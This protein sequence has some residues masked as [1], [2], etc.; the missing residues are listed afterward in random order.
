MTLPYLNLTA[1]IVLLVALMGT[2]AAL[3][4]GY[5]I[6]YMQRSEA[7]YLGLLQTQ[8][9][10][11]FQV[12]KVRQH[13]SDTSAIMYSVLTA[14][15]EEQQLQAPARLN[16]LQQKFEEDLQQVYPL[17][18]GR[19]FEL[20]IVHMQARQV[21]YAGHRA[22]A[23]TLSWR[24]GRAL[25]ILEQ[26]FWPALQKLQADLASTSAAA[27]DNFSQASQR[28]ARDTH[29]TMLAT[30]IL[31]GLSL[32]VITALT[33]WIALRH[34][35]LPI[36]RLTQSMQRLSEQ[37]Y[38]API[39]E[40][41]RHDE[42]GTMA[43][44]LQSFSAA[45]LKA[46]AMEKE[47]AQH[48]RNQL[49]VDQLRDLTSA[50]PGAVF[51]M[52]WRFG[53][54][55]QLRFASQQWAQLMGMEPGQDTSTSMAAR[56]LR[57][58]AAEATAISYTHFNHGA[59]HLE[60]LD[61]DVSVTMLDGVTRWIKTRANPHL[62]ADGSVTF[63]G[64]WLD[65]SKEVMQARALE[66]AKRQAEQVAQEKSTLQ[67][68]IS[69]E[70]RTPLN[71]ILGLTQLLL[72]T[73]L[74]CA[75]R[76]Q[77]QSVLRASQHLRGIVNEVL[78]F[79]KI[80]A[81][82]LQLE[83]TDFSLSDVL[84]DVLS[85]CREEASAKNLTLE[86]SIA[87]NVP[88]GL[89]GDSHRLAQILLNYVNNAIKFTMTG[90]IQVA[91]R[92]DTAS[93][94]HRI[95]LHASVQDT[96]LGI[97]A[98]RLPTLFTAFQQADK[99]ITRRFGGTGLGLTISRALA[100]L[101]GG[102][103][104]AESQ[105]GQGS[106]FWFTAVLEPARTPVASIAHAPYTSHPAPFQGQGMHVLVVDDHPLNR[107]VAQGMLHA[108]GFTTDAAE[109]G[110]QALERLQQHGPNFYACVFMDIQMP[111]LDGLS[112]TR[113][114][115]RLP[116]FETLPIIAMT[117]HTG[118]QDVLHC[119]EAGMNSHLA[120]PLLESALHA[121][122]HQ[123]LQAAAKG[124]GWPI[125]H[126]PVNTV[127]DPQAE[128]PVVFDAALLDELAELFDA[129]KLDQL[130]TQFAS[131]T[132]KRAH[133][134]IPFGE[135]HDWQALRREAHKLTGTAATFGLLRL[136]HLSTALSSSLK[137]ADAASTLA[138]THAIAACAEDGVAQ[139]RTYC[140]IRSVQA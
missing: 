51:Q 2:T 45:M 43:R 35:S 80:D 52:C 48:E 82:Q 14:Y 8:G 36:G 1:K 3:I 92:L 113:E 114:L 57:T 106:T 28:I 76:E 121:T 71:A 88:D 99:S 111:R 115:R 97:P 29:G 134:L 68:S 100:Q 32:L 73:D 69:H 75:Q 120:K 135:Q 37:Q 94:L 56:T 11:A 104:G 19:E 59:Q 87:S 46:K 102:T 49:L 39:S 16:A 15:T 125:A 96:G 81:G 122:L 54:P 33:A 101:M 93:T 50:L 124:S 27:Q 129:Q 105:L 34:V 130:I 9:Q 72:K 21:F 18:P 112:A 60:P 67:A 84:Q 91:I 138:L 95:V 86:Y 10:A 107:T 47:W 118:V 119:Q 13:I 109:D 22:I 7:Q 128:L 90:G 103:A 20:D 63:N 65:V 116:G 132:L 64:V 5:A 139:L 133:S 53:Q 108:A 117:A 79:S 110:H 78:D 98:D 89:R 26:A 62:E 127:A 58:H 6:W 24:E 85:M 31:G 38:G 25:R 83:S 74:P 17:L 137:A 41:E 140:T 42:L 70:I 126:T 61:F 55:L 131:D 23:V 44:T 136:G 77:L 40:Q 66:K 4:A 12:G 30:A 123:C